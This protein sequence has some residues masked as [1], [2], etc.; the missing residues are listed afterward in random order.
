MPKHNMSLR[1]SPGDGASLESS[2]SGSALSW[3]K[4]AYIHHNQ[5]PCHASSLLNGSDTTVANQSREW[6]IRF[7]RCVGVAY[8]HPFHRPSYNLKWHMARRTM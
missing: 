5:S 3:A 4:A 1:S 7:I 6:I 2:L 8:M